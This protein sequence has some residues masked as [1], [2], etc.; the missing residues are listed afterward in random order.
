M[1][2]KDFRNEKIYDAPVIEGLPR[3]FAAVDTAN[4]LRESRKQR[5]Y[6][7][8]RNWKQYQTT[9]K[10]PSI[11]RKIN[12]ELGGITNSAINAYRSGF[13][14][15]PQ[16]LVER[17]NRAVAQ[18][19][20]AVA[21]E[22]NIKRLQE[23]IKERAAQDPYYRPN[24]DLEQLKGLTQD[25][26]LSLDEELRQ[27]NEVLSNLNQSIG[28]DLRQ[29][30]D[31]EKAIS[32]YVNTI[33]KTERENDVTN[34]D[35]IQSK[36]YTS[37]RFRDDKGV[38]NVTDQHIEQLF[39]K[40]PRLYQSF[41]QDAVEQL[42]NDFS[43]YKAS[44]ATLPSWAKGLNDQ[45]IVDEL[46]N[47]PN[48]QKD[49]GLQPKELWDRI[50]DVARPAIKK[51]EDASTKSMYDA[52]K[53]NPGWG[54]GF[55]SNQFNAPTEGFN[56]GDYS[57]V[58][59]TITSKNASNPYLT[60]DSKTSARIDPATGDVTSSQS[61]RRFV[62]NNYHWAPY[63]VDNKGRKIP[64]KIQASDEQDL[65][66]KI[67]SLPVSERAKIAGAAP[68]L[69]G[70]SIDKANVLNLAYAKRNELQD[71][72]EANPLDDQAKAQL[73]GT[74]K[75][76]ED[77]NADRDLNG[78]LIQKY[79]GVDVQKNE[80]FIP[81]PRDSNV[82]DIQSRTGMDIYSDKSLS[83]EMKYVRDEINKIVNDTK[84]EF[85][86]YQDAQARKA[87]DE[88]RKSQEYIDMMSGKKKKPVVKPP[89]TL[90]SNYKINGKDYSLDDLKK[91]GYTED[92]L[93]EAQANGTIN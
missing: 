79:L 43:T 27:K 44:G 4:R 32:D 92:Q 53:R 64:L 1:A 2:Y 23:D 62:L 29:S 77:I 6:D 36:V 21:I 40:D 18:D 38:P 75:I 59:R 37:A 51:Y 78:Q 71:K 91:M 50:A 35:G 87:E 9:N 34:A 16:E 54:Y 8:E 65:V 30:F 31:R 14:T 85:K 86:N 90:K 76:L 88:K 42:A 82:K 68:V 19:K 63:T 28:K 48:K 49:I 41:Q 33:G 47:D 12:S 3:T 17:Q 60:F 61:P 46:V 84:P 45:D 56:T 52:E 26:D 69:N 10:I 57:G 13:Q 83:P 58:S 66:N 25:N 5:Q 81:D 73:A 72:V 89:V 15:L 7:L 24:F 67:K 55:T 70:Y 39:N 74:E 22:E 80:M 11:T 93:K 20:E